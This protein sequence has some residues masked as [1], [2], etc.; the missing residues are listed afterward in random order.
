MKSSFQAG[1]KREKKTSGGE[2]QKEREVT[3]AQICCAQIWFLVFL[4][5]S[6]NLDSWRV[7]EANRVLKSCHWVQRRPLKHHY[8]HLLLCQICAEGITFIMRPTWILPED[9]TVL[10]YLFT[11]THTFTLIHV[12]TK[13]PLSFR[14]LPVS[15][16]HNYSSPSLSL[17]QKRNK[18]LFIFHQYPLPLTALWIG[19]LWGACGK[20]LVTNP[21]SYYCS[22]QPVYRAQSFSRKL[23]LPNSTVKLRSKTYWAAF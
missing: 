1:I 5:V 10:T 6:I 23:K 13:V 15:T 8:Y 19:A 21:S 20:W 4:F 17:S 12:C 9:R 14:D 11:F 16:L 2:L 7:A 3:E 18:T 22:L